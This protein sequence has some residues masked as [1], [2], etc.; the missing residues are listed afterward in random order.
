M[1]VNIRRH[2]RGRVGR[3]HQRVLLPYGDRHRERRKLARAARDDGARVGRA[4]GA[5]APAHGKPKI[6]K[7][8]PTLE[9]FAPR[10]IEG[11]ARANRLK[12]SGCRGQG[13][14]SAVAPD[15][16]NSATS[17]RRDQQRAGAATEAGPGGK[18]P[19]TVNNVLSVLSMLLKQA[20]EWG[21][22]D[23]RA[24]FDSPDASAA[25]GRR[26]SRL[27]GVR[28]VAGGRAD[29]RPAQLPDRTPRWRS[30]TTSGRDRGP[31]VGRRRSRPAADSCGTRTGTGS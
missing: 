6:R 3:R 20:V 24:L 19:K 17:A 14:D 15:P 4:A 1:S 23:K 13:V 11:Y 25:D 27:R 9:A 30:G 8:V 22:L 16:R 18:S 29:D 5:T 26:V 21:V 28:A 12:P 10:F 7:E 2:P 31:R